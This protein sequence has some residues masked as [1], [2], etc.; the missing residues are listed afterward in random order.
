MTLGPFPPAVP[1]LPAPFPAQTQADLLALLESVFPTHYL[2]P[3]RDV[4]PGYE[5]QQ[6]YARM[7]EYASLVLEYVATGAF[8]LSAEGPAKAQVTVRFLRDSGVAG[9]VTVKRGTIVAAPASGRQFVTLDDA[10]FVGSATGPIEVRAEARFYGWIY[11][12]PG[13]VTLDSGEVLEG[14]IS[15]VVIPLQDPVLADP[16]I[17][18]EQVS[19][20]TGGRLGMLDALGRDRGIARLPS[21]T[22]AAYRHRVRALP[23]TITPD[24]VVRTLRRFFGPLGLSAS[25]IETWSAEYQTCYDAPART[26]TGLGAAYDPN[27]FCFDDPRTSPPFRNRWLSDADYRGAFIVVVPALAFQHDVGMIYDDTAAG[28]AYLTSAPANGRRAAGAYDVAPA[29]VDTLL[30]GAYDGFDPVVR[31]VYKGLLEV[32]REIKAAGVYVTVELEGQ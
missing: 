28:A 31:A 20:A 11:N 7:M 9:S 32:L 1:T 4:G 3:L 2:V 14:E 24:A 16:T 6:A 21:E 29:C 26:Y 12:L 27:L 30:Q 5:L 18:V 10:V 17:Q 25:F 23:D 13:P 22:D 15:E 19:D 8:I